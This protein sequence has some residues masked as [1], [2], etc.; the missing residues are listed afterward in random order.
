MI[1]TKTMNKRIGIILALIVLTCNNSVSAQSFLNKKVSASVGTSCVTPMFGKS[2]NNGY[3][4]V[5]YDWSIAPAELAVTLGWAFNS[6]GTV[7]FSSSFRPLRNSSYSVYNSLETTDY[8]EEHLD[9]FFIRTKALNFGLGIRLFD[10]FAPVGRYIQFGL[11]VSNI[12]AIVSP[13]LTTRRSDFTYNDI[14]EVTEINNLPE[15]SESRLSYGLFLG[16]GITRLLSESLLIDFGIKGNWYLGSKQYSNDYDPFT[17][18]YSFDY[19]GNFGNPIRSVM[20]ANL[21]SSYLFSVYLKIGI[22]K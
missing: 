12:S 14:D 21:Q 3:A 11:N 13:R 8:L 7:Q 6:R 20:L 15:W 10:E 4:G 19:Q 2:F 5:D 17:D 9:T 22:I 1:T 18:K 16:R